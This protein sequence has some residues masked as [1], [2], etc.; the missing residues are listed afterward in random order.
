[1][2]KLGGIKW[3]TIGVEGTDIVGTDSGVTAGGN[4]V[5][6]IPIIA[7]VSFGASTI[8]DIYTNWK[9]LQYQKGALDENRRYWDDYIRNTGVQPRYPYRSGLYQNTSFL[10]SGVVRSHTSL[11]SVGERGFN[12]YSSTD[13]AQKRADR[14]AVGRYLSQY[15]YMW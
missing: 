3:L 6:I 8:Y 10:Y 14:R 12:L 7:G 2:N 15:D 9:N 1:M 11:V 5:P 13:R 4:L